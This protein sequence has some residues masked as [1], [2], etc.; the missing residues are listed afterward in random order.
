MTG[1]SENNFYTHISSI[2][3]SK[4]N[5]TIIFGKLIEKNIRNIFAQKSY[6]KCGR[7]TILRPLSKKSKP[8]IALNY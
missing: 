2:S 4:G 3:R 6:K 1:W 8:S 7:E 5:Q